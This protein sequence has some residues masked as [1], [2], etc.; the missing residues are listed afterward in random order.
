[1]RFKNRFFETKIL[2]HT[3]CFL[4][5]RANKR[6]AKEQKEDAK[7]RQEAKEKGEKEEEPKRKAEPKKPRNGLKR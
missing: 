2:V 7:L 3:L 1:M 6:I 5:T 4:T